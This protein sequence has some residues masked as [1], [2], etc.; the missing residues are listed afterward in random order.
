MSEKARSV[1]CC[2][3]YSLALEGD[4]E[5]RMVDDRDE[6]WWRVMTRAVVEDKVG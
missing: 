2:S 6:G 1:P 5:R 4:R 3:L